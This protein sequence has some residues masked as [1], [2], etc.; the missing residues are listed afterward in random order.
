MSNYCFRSIFAEYLIR[1]INLRRSFGLKFASQSGILHKFDGYVYDLS[2]TGLL[3][4]ELAIGFATAN[5]NVTAQE[6]ARRYATIRNFSDFL[7]TFEPQTPLLDPKALYARRVR[8][9]AHIYSEEELVRLLELAKRIA[10]KNP[11]RGFALHAMVGLAA[12]T[13]LRISEVVA[14]DRADVDMKSG[15]IMVR[16]TKFFKDRLVPV[17]S[18]VLAVLNQYARLRD[19]AHPQSQSPAFFLHQWGRRF[20]KHT[21]QMTYWD[22]TRRAGLR[23]DSGDGPTFHDLRHTF[24]VRRLAAWYRE[25]KDVNAMLPM[26]ATYMGHAHY[27]DTAYY[28]T[29][30]PELM[31]LAAQRARTSQT[32]SDKEATR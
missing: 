28:I 2:H 15:V 14:L 30:I 12:G 16:R 19:A 29:A 13:G 26:L 10:P 7:A 18:T 25:G 21:L 17:H 8:P 27:T 4:Q 6:C 32:S 9:P 24:A 1:Y 11:M 22:L 23:G 5:P 20:S 31:E 3:T